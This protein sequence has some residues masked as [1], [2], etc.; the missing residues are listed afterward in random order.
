MWAYQIIIFFLFRIRWENT[1]LIEGNWEERETK[2]FFLN[3][4]VCMGNYSRN[5]AHKKKSLTCIRATIGL[6]R[7]A[8]IRSQFAVLLWLWL[9]F[10]CSTVY[11]L[12]VFRYIYCTCTY[13]ITYYQHAVLRIRIPDLHQVR[14]G[15][16]LWIRIFL[17]D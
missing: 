4:T 5:L 8:W 12:R 6:C 1:E 2:E 7:I 16:F 11:N 17:L 10:L 13:N 9:R 3:V 14:S 15:L